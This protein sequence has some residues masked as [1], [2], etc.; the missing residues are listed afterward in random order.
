MG[1]PCGFQAPGGA[2]RPASGLRC[3][4]RRWDRPASEVERLRRGAADEGWELW[5]CVSE[6]LLTTTVAIPTPP[7]NTAPP[8]QAGAVE[9]A[10]ALA[11]G[12]VVVCIARGEDGGRARLQTPGG[13]V[14]AVAADG[15]KLLEALPLPP[16]LP[17]P[18]QPDFERA[19]AE[20]AEEAPQ[21]AAAAG[22]GVPL[23]P[24]AEVQVLAEADARACVEAPPPPTRAI[25]H[26]AL[27]ELAR[28]G[29]PEMIVHT[30]FPTS[31]LEEEVYPPR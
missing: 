31:L 19:T 9:I 12:E 4:R 6:A 30:D 8:G 21:S 7:V 11:A 26:A 2:W 13:W 16:A 20:A 25:S 5:R 17:A 27:L 29:G 18:R 28:R 14:S 10:G 23:V 24:G 3:R 22:S 15:R 1:Q